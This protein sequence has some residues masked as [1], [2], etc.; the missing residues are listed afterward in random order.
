MNIAQFALQ[1][2]IIQVIINTIF[3]K[4]DIISPGGFVYIC[5]L[6]LGGLINEELSDAFPMVGSAVKLL[7]HTESLIIWLD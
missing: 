5:C 6:V 1:A 7:S 3:P 2:S 4:K